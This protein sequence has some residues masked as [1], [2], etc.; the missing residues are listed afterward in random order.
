MHDEKLQ[1][2]FAPLAALLEQ[3]LVQSHLP[4]PGAMPASLAEFTRWY[5][6]VIQLLEVHAAQGGEHAPM[7]RDEVELM[8]RCAMSG[9]TLQACIE[10]TR[11][12]CVMLQPRAGRLSL[13]VNGSTARLELDSQRD[14]PTAASNL[15]DI[16]G[17]F[18]FSQLFQWLAGR[19]LPLE[20]VSIG[21]ILRDDVLPFLRL[22]RA[23]VLAGG[24]YYALEFESRA[25]A[26]PNVRTGGEFDAFFAVF[27]C[28]MFGRSEIN[29]PD[30][31]SALL[32]AAVHQGEAPPTQEEVAVTLGI[33]LSS[34]RRQLY[35][36]GRSFRELREACL[37]ESAI[38]LLQRGELSVAGVAQR[39]GFSD[40]GAFRRAFSRWTGMS[41][42]AYLDGRS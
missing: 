29:L 22:F 2:A 31:V 32:Y 27:P 5:L 42:S 12:Y 36:Q 40:A 3:E 15:A 14:Q 9:G 41:P 4:S 18:A 25:L 28:G 23:P 26:W 24:E 19:E 37:S 7:T 38:G 17:L 35:A 34:M 8:C 11:R 33:P 39:L 13:E 16:S 10:L 30:Q 20:R 1:N 6:Q 21:P